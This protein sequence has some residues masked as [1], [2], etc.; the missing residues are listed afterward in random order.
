MKKEHNSRKIA[1]I[2]KGEI[3]TGDHM[4]NISH[5]INANTRFLSGPRQQNALKET[6]EANTA[7]QDLNFTET[8]RSST[9][10]QITDSNGDTHSITQIDRI[11][12]ANN[13]GQTLILN[14]NNP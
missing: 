1:G 12:M 7:S 5:A 8:S 9:T 6:E 14:F 10:V 2:R 13:S 4:T 11:E 3:I